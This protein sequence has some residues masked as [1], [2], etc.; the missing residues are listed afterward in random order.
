MASIIKVDTIQTAAGGTPTAADLGLNVTGA[1]LQVK[2]SIITS[3][4]STS[5][6]SFVS[7]G[8]SVNITPVSS[9]SKILILATGNAG[10]GNNGLDRIHFQIG[11]MTSTNTG[12]AATGFETS[13]TICPRS[14]DTGWAQNPFHITLMDSP[15]TTSA[16]TYTLLWAAANSANTIYLNSAA[17]S[18]SLVG[19]TP[20]T[21]TVMEIAG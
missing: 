5:S 19:N 12:D 7:T 20:T 1:I 16:L 2:N 13:Q 3:K 18:D 4:I 21:L 10:I 9:T 11:G 14:A 8:L 17:N 6:T 15:N